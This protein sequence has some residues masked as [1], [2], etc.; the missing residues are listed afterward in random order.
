MMIQEMTS[1]FGIEEI[2]QSGYDLCQK[3]PEKLYDGE[4]IQAS[5][6]LEYTKHWVD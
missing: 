5:T 1:T 6:M 2:V 3:H 4:K